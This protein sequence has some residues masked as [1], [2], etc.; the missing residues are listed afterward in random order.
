MWNAWGL[1]PLPEFAHVRRYETVSDLERLLGKNNLGSFDV[2]L[3]PAALSDFAPKAAKRKIS[4]ETPALRVDLERLPKVILD[5]RRRAPKSFLVAFKAESEAGE[6]LPRS[7]D[8][9][10]KYNADLVVGNATDAFGAETSR[11][12]VVPKKGA[13]RRLRGS[14]T[15]IATHVMSEVAKRL[16][17]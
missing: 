14:K 13:P 17:R 12:V 2:I 8:R 11:V 6:V 7:R 15:E 1:V 16:G 9:L 5:V 10:K 4:S 3:M